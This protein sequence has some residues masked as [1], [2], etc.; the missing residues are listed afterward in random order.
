MGTAFRNI[1]QALGARS[2]PVAEGRVQRSTT[3]PLVLLG[4]LVIGAPQL[5]GGVFPWTIAVT[6]T[7]ALLTLAAT[8][9][10]THATRAGTVSW[11]ALAVCGAAA[12]TVVQTLPLPCSVVAWL[13]PQSAAEMRAALALF[14]GA[15]ATW[16]ALSRD[17]GATRLEVLKGIAIA[18]TFLSASQLAACS[19][20]DRDR[21][22]LLCAYSALAMSVVAHLHMAL[23]LEEVFG[24]Y[25]PREAGH[26]PQLAP[27]MNPNNLGAFAALGVPLWL[28]TIWRHR[29]PR[30]RAIAAMATVL[31]AT[32]AVLSLS[33]SAIAML[34]GCIALLVFF[35][36]ARAFRARRDRAHRGRQPRLGPRLAF[37]LSLAV[38]VALAAYLAAD[39]VLLEFRQGSTTKLELI[40]RAFRFAMEQPLFGVGRGAFGSTF[41]SSGS[42]DHVYYA[43][44]ENFVSQWAVDWGL[45]VTLAL[46]AALVHALWLSLR[47]A[48]SPLRLGAITGVIGLA[49]QNLVDLNLELVGVAV[50]AASLL[51]AV[52]VPSRRSA[53]RAGASRLNAVPFCVTVASVSAAL[54]LWLGPGVQRYSRDDIAASLN[55]RIDAKNR[56]PFRALLDRA[57]R[58]H[59]SEPVFAVLAAHE[60]LVQGDRRAPRW[61]NRAMLLAPGW[62]APHVQAFQWLWRSGRRPQA[63]LEMRA[64]AEISPTV[65]RA[66]VCDVAAA[67]SQPVLKAAPRVRAERIEFLEL[68]ARCVAPESA[69]SKAIDAVLRR[70][71]PRSAAVRERDALRLSIDG[72]LDEALAELD[73]ALRLDPLRERARVLRVQML[74]QHQRHAEAA[75]VAIE[76]AR[77]MPPQTAAQLWALRARALSALHDQNGWKSALDAVRRLVSD[78]I[79][80]LADT[81]ALE[82]DLY[83][84]NG[85]L[86]S[87]MRSYKQAYGI[88]EDSKYLVSYA[89]LCMAL[90]DKRAALWAFMRLC[91][92]AS[93]T[94][95]HCDTRDSLLEETRAMNLGIKLRN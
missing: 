53:A 87:A 54:L 81:Y 5:F 36:S 34:F 37:G 55:E 39:R 49:A 59:P 89:G 58:L 45:P 72:K 18:A 56:G 76:L 14:D 27:L 63:L 82:A 68:A 90:G 69:V 71:A 62:A 83:R 21:V 47:E 73:A 78:D 15:P 2:A 86:A 29:E 85:Q 25:R 64:A 26:S 9:W 95:Q 51:A 13:A 24:V 77:S 67:G 33:R 38:A 61:I 40:A 66:Y 32:T 7:G 30:D 20:R 48:E 17:P 23:G 1:Q 12:W 42:R 88:K 10:A 43:H 19:A 50:V 93:G 22:I 44:A 92:L 11:L 6:A 65:V 4:T 94:G 80:R 91:E 60:A 35:L 74:L 8:L 3:L 16:C 75:R 31:T 28:A 52:A 41:V 84:Q 79:D 57:V 46:L 70:D